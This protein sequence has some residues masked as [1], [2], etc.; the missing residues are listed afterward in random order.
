M[1]TARGTELSRSIRQKL[2]ELKKACAE[3]DDATASRAPEGRWSPKEILSH[4][5][6]PEGSGHLPLFQAFLNKSPRVDLHPG[7]PFFT[8]HRRRMS[9]SDILEEV[10]KEYKE[11][12]GFVENLSDEELER[13]AY[14][15]QLKDSPLGDH[16]S[17]EK[18]IQGV[19]DF[20]LQFHID[21]LREILQELRK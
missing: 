1:A 11:I 2:E 17:L 15:P 12:A 21:H 19:G 14:V 16:P 9:V 4:L 3:L 20:H 18:I 10:E 13:T 7:D 6:G 8:E 5:C